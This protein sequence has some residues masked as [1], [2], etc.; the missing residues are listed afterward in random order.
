MSD[1]GKEAGSTNGDSLGEALSLNAGCAVCPT[2]RPMADTAELL[3]GAR[4]VYSTPVLSLSDTYR[5]PVVTHVTHIVSCLVSCPL[6][7][8]FFH[9]FSLFFLCACLLA[10]L[11]VCWFVLT[12]DVPSVLYFHQFLFHTPISS[13]AHTVTSPI[14]THLF[15]TVNCL[16]SYSRCLHSKLP[17][18]LLT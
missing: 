6:F 8:C 3:V 10:Y 4:R 11:F 16:I 13:V 15:H 17:S 14:S 5:K 12:Y 7:L 1:R 2:L 9:L 18:Q